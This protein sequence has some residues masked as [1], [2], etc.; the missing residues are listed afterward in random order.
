MKPMI[1]NLW[2]AKCLGRIVLNTILSQH[3]NFLM[4]TLRMK[5]YIFLVCVL[6]VELWWVVRREIFDI[7][8][9]LM[10][11]CTL[12]NSWGYILDTYI[13]FN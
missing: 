10:H 12:P 6:V 3:N 13:V 1:D 7:R 11:P 4:A 2:I 9:E 5:S 8:S